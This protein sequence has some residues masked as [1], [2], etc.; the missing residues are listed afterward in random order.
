[1]LFAQKTNRYLFNEWIVYTKD[2]LSFNVSSWYLSTIEQNKFRVCRFLKWHAGN[3]KF[4]TNSWSLREYKKKLKMDD[5]IFVLPKL[6]NYLW[7]FFLLKWC[8]MCMTIG[9]VY[10]GKLIVYSMKK[11]D[12]KKFY[13]KRMFEQIH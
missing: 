3:A 5:Q 7:I 4:K 11:F 13:N 8:G 12:K 1:M 2:V 6:T 10:I 9:G